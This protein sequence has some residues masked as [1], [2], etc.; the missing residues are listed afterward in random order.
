MDKMVVSSRNLDMIISSIGDLPATP[1]IISTL[2]G[3]T[4]D[5]NTDI[6][7]ITKA[8]SS[9]QSL[10]ARVLKLSNST[11]YGRTKEVR[12]LK[13]A[14]LLLGFKT[15]RSMV[16]ASS[17]HSL[18]QS[19]GSGGAQEKLWEH[20]LATAIA[21]RLV[22]TSTGHPLA[23]EAFIAG[24]LHDIGKLVLLQKRVKEYKEIITSVEA[25]GGTFQ[26]VE[27]QTFGFNHTDVGLLLLHKWSF[28]PVLANAVFEHHDPIDTDTDIIPLSYIIHFSNHFAKLLPIGFGDF[29]VEDLSTL[30]SMNRLGL[31]TDD[32]E[33]LEP[34]LAEQF[35]CE[36]E[37]LAAAQGQS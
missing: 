3:L 8:I 6:D 34:A 2:M 27:E 31:S 25:S 23:E 12:T 21:S 29:R 35:A 1:A 9:D 18:Y 17:T 32:L 28:P 22:A 15:L 4:S 20:S 13:E 11:F 33:T 37:I 10:T 30:T 7:K 16:V 14:I 24:L 36:K 5:I 26:E 19:A